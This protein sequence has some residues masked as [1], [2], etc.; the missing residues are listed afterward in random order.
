MTIPGLPSSLPS[1]GDDIKALVRRIQNIE[2]N[3]AEMS[4]ALGSAT[5]MTFTDGQII[6]PNGTSIVV[7][8][9]GTV[10]VQDADG[11]RA[12]TLGLLDDASFGLQVTDPVSGA[13]LPL[14]Q[15]AFGLSAVSATAAVAG[16]TKGVWTADGLSFSVSCATGRLLILIGATITMGAPTGANLVQGYYGYSLAGPSPA[17]ASPNRAVFTEFG[18]FAFQGMTAEV[19]TGLTPGTYTIAGATMR[20][21]NGADAPPTVSITNRSIICLPF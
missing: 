8:G 10:Q 21:T 19:H 4:Q 15:L 1:G 7:E 16:G 14:S 12:V 18:A 17:A 11:N 20:T 6:V 5:G 13:S 9:G 2:R 3:Q